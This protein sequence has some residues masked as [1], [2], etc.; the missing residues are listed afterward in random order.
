MERNDWKVKLNLDRTVAVEPISVSSLEQHIG[1]QKHNEMFL[2]ANGILMRGTEWRA[3]TLGSSSHHV[4]AEL[5][6]SIRD[7]HPIFQRN[8]WSGGSVCTGSYLFWLL[9]SRRLEVTVAACW[10]RA[11]GGC[12]SETASHT[13]SHLPVCRLTNG[14]MGE[15]LIVFCESHKVGTACRALKDH[16]QACFQGC[17]HPFSELATVRYDEVYNMKAVS[18]RGAFNDTWKAEFA[19]PPTTPPQIQIAPAAVVA[20]RRWDTSHFPQD[21]CTLSTEDL[22]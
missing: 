4:C 2:T 14:W 1:K 13:F 21:S 11:V 17:P 22:V 7:D 12:D 19:F 10:P 20:G 8:N 16:D 15:T 18:E 3:G 6:R 9:Q 5:P